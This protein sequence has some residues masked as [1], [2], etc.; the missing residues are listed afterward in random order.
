[1]TR[2]SQFNSEQFVDL[3]RDTECVK[4]YQLHVSY[5]YGDS[6]HEPLK[7]RVVRELLKPTGIYVAAPQPE[8][9]GQWDLMKRIEVEKHWTETLYQTTTQ[10]R[11]LFGFIKLRPIVTRQPTGERHRSELSWVDAID[12]IVE[13]NGDAIAEMAP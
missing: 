9:S 11:L 8:G 3:L 2:L 10:E 1:M 13:R 4:F 12:I 5:V 6:V 7:E